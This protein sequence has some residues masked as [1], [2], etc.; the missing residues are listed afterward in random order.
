M[1]MRFALTVLGNFLTCI[2]FGR[3]PSQHIAIFL[4]LMF[5]STFQGIVNQG[6]IQGGDCPPLKSTTVTLFTMIL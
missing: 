6:R 2:S 5:L 1:V 4:R 3:G